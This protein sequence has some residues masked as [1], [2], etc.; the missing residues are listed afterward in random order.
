MRMSE[1]SALMSREEAIALVDTLLVGVAE[2]EQGQTLAWALWAMAPTTAT[3]DYQRIIH[4]LILERGLTSRDPRS[5]ALAQLALARTFIADRRFDLAA[6]LLEGESQLVSQTGL[7]TLERLRRALLITAQLHLGRLGEALS[8]L[9]GLKGYERD[10]AD[11]RVYCHEAMALSA[12]VQ[13]DLR[14]AALAFNEAVQDAARHAHKELSAWQAARGSAGGAHVAMRVGNASVA[15]QL[16]ASALTLTEPFSAISEVS[17]LLLLRAICQSAA[18]E[19]IDLEAFNKGLGGK[20]LLEAQ[21]GATDLVSGFPVDLSGAQNLGE[22]ARAFE[23]AISERQ[24]AHDAVGEALA[25][26][27]LVLTLHV[28]ERP[29]D[30]AQTLARCAESVSKKNPALKAWFD[31]TGRLLSGA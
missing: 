3:S 30:C 25:S 27:G 22:G 10:S 20:G 24:R 28:H 2:E 29:Q 6:E 23:E 31:A 13:G 14:A 26:I 15:L 7:A 11:F 21:G 18:G 19:P 9:E 4:S 1:L 16:L 17:D 8:A 12:L 5:H